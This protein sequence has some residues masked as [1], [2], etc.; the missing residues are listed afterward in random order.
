MKEGANI[1]LTILSS[2]AEKRYGC[3]GETAKPRI[4]FKWPVS[5]SFSVPDAKSQ[6]CTGHTQHSNSKTQTMSSDTKQT[7][8]AVQE[9]FVYL[10]VP[11]FSP[12]GKRACACAQR[13][14]LPQACGCG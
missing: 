1:H 5:V 12:Y 6:I 3:R 14:G 10:C 4:Q 9:G 11:K 2:P 13:S 7:T 8:A